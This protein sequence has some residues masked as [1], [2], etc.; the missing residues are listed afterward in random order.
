[1]FHF[2][3]TIKSNACFPLYSRSTQWLVHW[4]SSRE[5]MPVCCTLCRPQPFA[6]PPMNSPSTFCRNKRV[7]NIIRHG[8]WP[9]VSLCP[10]IFWQRPP[11]KCDWTR[12]WAALAMCCHRPGPVRKN[13]KKNNRRVGMMTQSR[14]SRRLSDRR[15]TNQPRPDRYCHESFLRCQ[16][17][18]FTRRRWVLTQCTPIRERH[19]SQACH[20]RD[21]V[22]ALS[23]LYVYIYI[24]TIYVSRRIIVS[25]CAVRDG[26]NETNAS[27]WLVCVPRKYPDKKRERTMN[28][29]NKK[30]RMEESVR[31]TRE[32][33]R[34]DGKY[35][36]IVGNLRFIF[37]FVESFSILLFCVISREN[38]RHQTHTPPRDKH[39]WWLHNEFEIKF[40]WGFFK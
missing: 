3:L 36:E 2:P 37:G 29:Q 19:E 38:D 7:M 1:M 16:V 6:G 28:I 9:L 22:A 10:R 5:S 24:S 12:N 13:S 31:D 23:A 33:E 18:A 11:K 20:L 15:E 27:D 26:M 14:N 4:A 34:E 25:R 8:S 40:V 39:L 21:V 17:L 30:K 32:K 35:S